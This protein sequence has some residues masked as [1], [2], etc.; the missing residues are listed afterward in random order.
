MNMSERIDATPFWS[1][2][3]PLQSLSCAVLLIAASDRLSHGLIVSLSAILS[4]SLA[5]LLSGLGERSVPPRARTFVRVITVS[6]VGAIVAR[7]A[8]LAWPVTAFSLS[9]YLGAIPVCILASRVLDSAESRGALRAAADAAREAL[10]LAVLIV[11][12]ALVRE[13]LGYGVLSLPS[14][15]GYFL[16]LRSELL[17]SVAAR[18]V[19][20][21]AGALILLSYVLA[22]HRR[23]RF[24]LFGIPVNGAGE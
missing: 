14:H 11:A 15:D 1:P 20:A 22:L 19:S 18:A 13:P 5:P 21:T 9:L 23:V 17:Q 10:V 24:R 8:A 6:A 12:L 7:M 3:G 16:V 2:R 4:Y